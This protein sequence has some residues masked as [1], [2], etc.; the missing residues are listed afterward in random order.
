MD[1]LIVM[2]I[3]VLVGRFLYPANKK[4]INEKLQLLCTLLLTFSMGVMLANKD[5]FFQE[6][7]TLGITSFIFYLIPTGLSILLVYVLSKRFMEKQ[8]KF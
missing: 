8:D 3:G 6:L 4:R 5:N 1:I 2:C 7:T